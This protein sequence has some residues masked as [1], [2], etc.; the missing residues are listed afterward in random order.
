MQK[1]SWFILLF[2]ACK[3]LSLAQEISIDSSGL[4]LI[5]ITHTDKIVKNENDEFQRFIGAVV[6]EHDGINMTCDSAF[7]YLDKNYVEAFSNVNIVKANGTNAHSNYMK[8]TGNNNT[9]FMQGNVSIIDGGNT[10]FTEELTYNIKTKIGKYYKG[11]TLQTEGTNLSSETGT[12]NGYSQQTYFVKDVIVTNEKY[13]IQSKELTY[14]IKTKVVKLL[15]ES[16]IVSDNSTI[17]SN[18]GTYDSKNGQANFTSRTTIETD[19]QIIIG[20]TMTYNEKSGMGH[21]K[22]NVIMVDIKNDT[23]LTSKEAEY[24]KQSGFGKATGNVRIE[25]E[26]GKSILFCEVVEYNKK[27]GYAIAKENVEFI[28]TTQH[29]TLLAGIVEFNEFTKFMMATVHPKLITLADNDSLYMRAD[30]MLSLREKDKTKLEKIPIE[31]S[32]KKIKTKGFTYNLLFADSTAKSIEGEE[33]AKLIIANRHI[34]MFAD[35]MQAVCDSLSYSQHDS[36]FRLY[37]NPIMWSKSQQSNADT[38][39][40]H[41]ENNKLKELNLINNALLVS[42]TGYKTMYDQV[43]GIYIDAFF[44]QN[45]I[46]YVHVNQNAESIYFAKDDDNAY[47]GA[48]R[49]ECAEMNVYFKDKE[50]NRI[51]FL[52]DPKGDFFPIDKLTEAKRYLSSFKLFNELKPKSRQEILED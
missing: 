20:N 46:Q 7:L 31:S 17:Y 44:I 35:S 41:T 2:L 33:E 25:N 38:I 34:K 18:Q 16:T 37:K 36:T 43:A 4:K 51:V 15:D 8:Y 40:I 22:G 52:N 49:A 1:T 39:F 32:N 45:E 19:D 9:A 28:D 50:V 30:T 48:N 47:I 11:G 14:N 27:S 13:N 24:N 21:A 12:Y 3:Q 42:E 5:R 29:T 23:K 10:L 26:G 6:I